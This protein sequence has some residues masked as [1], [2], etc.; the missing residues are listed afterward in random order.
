LKSWR[1]IW[2]RA[3]FVLATAA[4]GCDPVVSVAGAEFPVWMLC[5]ITGILVVLSLRPL[6]IIAGIDEWMTPRPLTYSSLA[7]VVAFL[8]WL[9]IWKY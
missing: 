2:L 6:L 8:C 4:V 9:L 7:M 1:A 3:V 5:L